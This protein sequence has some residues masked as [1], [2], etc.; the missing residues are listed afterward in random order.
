MGQSR[1]IF[2]GILSVLAAR[3]R[4][5]DVLANQMAVLVLILHPPQA[6]PWPEKYKV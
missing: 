6:T 3:R 2:G 4:C 5:C 1:V